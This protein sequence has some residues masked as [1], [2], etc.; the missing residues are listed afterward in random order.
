[1][2]LAGFKNSRLL[3]QH[4]EQEACQFLKNKGFKLITQNFQCKS[5]EIDLIMEDSEM[6][7]FVEVRYR[8]TQNYGGG[9]HSISASKQKKIIQTALLYLQQHNK[10]EEQACRFD[11]ISICQQNNQSDITWIP[12]AFTA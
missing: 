10:Y 12:S 2:N 7:V 11:V 8:K 4:Y 3:G 9:T 6:L 5:G 1:M